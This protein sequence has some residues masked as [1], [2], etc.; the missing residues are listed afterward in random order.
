M[1]LAELGRRSALGLLRYEQ[2]VAELAQLQTVRV[3]RPSR[4]AE[5]ETTHPGDIFLAEHVPTD[6][7]KLVG[8][9]IASAPEHV[10]REVGIR[11]C[12]T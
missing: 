6:A 11:G 5:A 7:E 10:A 3:S 9:G 8:L 12:G 1:R 2:V 4:A